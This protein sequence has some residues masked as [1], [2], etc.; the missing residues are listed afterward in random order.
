MSA[1]LAGVKIVFD[2]FFW[3]IKGGDC[4]KVGRGL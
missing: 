3:T 2:D 4:D 1:R